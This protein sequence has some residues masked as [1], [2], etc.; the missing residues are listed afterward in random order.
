VPPAGALLNYISCGILL[1]I[2]SQTGIFAGFSL[3]K[4][5]SAV[6]ISEAA[7]KGVGDIIFHKLGAQWKGTQSYCDFLLF[8]FYIMRRKDQRSCDG[9]GGGRGT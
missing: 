9:C 8:F 4:I 2:F 3:H 7:M 5:N 1:R 6:R